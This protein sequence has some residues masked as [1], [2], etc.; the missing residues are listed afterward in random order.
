MQA[1][2]RGARTKPTPV[3]FENAE[4]TGTKGKPLS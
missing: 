3:T 2:S 4:R 1:R